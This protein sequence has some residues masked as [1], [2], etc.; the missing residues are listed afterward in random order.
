[1]D[2]IKLLL[3]VLMLIP[4]A[5][6]LINSEGHA[7]KITWEVSQEKTFDKKVQDVTFGVFE[8]D[9]EEHIYPKIVVFEDEIR[10]YNERGK[11]I[12][13]IRK[14]SGHRFSSNRSYIYTNTLTYK[15]T[16][17]ENFEAYFELEVFDQNGCKIWERKKP[18]WYDVSPPGFF[19]L[20]NGAAVEIWG[21]L[22]KFNFLDEN[23]RLIKGSGYFSEGQGIGHGYFA[24][25]GNG[26]LIVATA[27]KSVAPLSVD[28][29]IKKW[30]NAWLILYT[31]DGEELWRRTLD[32]FL[33]GCMFIN[34]D[35]RYIVFFGCNVYWKRESTPYAVFYLFNGDGNLI[36][37]YSLEKG[38]SRGLSVAFSPDNSFVVV[39]QGSTVG[40][41]ELSNGKLLWEKRLPVVK[42]SNLR[43]SSSGYIFVNNDTREYIH[44]REGVTE[45]LI[46]VSQIT[47][48]DK[49]G[50]VVSVKEFPNKISFAH[51]LDDGK[52]KRVWCVAQVEACMKV[53]RIK[54]D[55]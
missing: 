55:N 10:F 4:I 44:G 32:K 7:Q 13:S 31:K 43:V 49:M 19:L 24:S 14:G 52:E 35:G 23:G 45:Q 48:L 17:K 36:G 1:M 26:E 34:E 8:K 18:L 27:M 38:T 5:T 37:K 29:P 20:N 46:D 21:Q 6:Q 40:L 47:V 22:G 25:S 51:V 3:V 30:E 53:Y 15:N 54:E 42:V 33:S 28:A 50:K 41:I 11:V 16:S 39:S 12:K 2:K 9:W